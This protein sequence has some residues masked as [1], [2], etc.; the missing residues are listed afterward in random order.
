MFFRKK[1]KTTLLED[2]E[3]STQWVA[4]ALISS[5]YQA[6]YSIESLKEID[7]FL[8][9][10]NKPDGILSKDVGKILFALGSYVGNVFI[11]KYGGQ[12]V[13]DDK[14]RQGEI[15]IM[16][17]LDN[18]I[19]LMPVVSVMKCYESVEEHSLYVLSKAI[20]QSL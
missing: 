14:D 1:R 9:E 17:V 18:D 16:A 12:W 5:N 20:E 10:E 8:T 4:E 6:D 2:I 3:T 13:T 15:K 7:R 11:K 19:T